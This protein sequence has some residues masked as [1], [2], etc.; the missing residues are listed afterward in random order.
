[1]G[2]TSHWL[3]DLFGGFVAKAPKPSA[4]VDM[5]DSGSDS[6]NKPLANTID[7]KTDKSTDVETAPEPMLKPMPVPINKP[8]SPLLL[9]SSCV[10]HNVEWMAGMPKAN[11]NNWRMNQD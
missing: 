7:T 3:K 9:P 11:I 6:N 1:M 2:N 10:A 5:M 4:V 8:P